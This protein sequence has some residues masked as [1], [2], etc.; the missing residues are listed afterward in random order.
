MRRP[1]V[2]MGWA[3]WAKSRRPPNAGA[4]EFQAKKSKIIS[5]LQ[6]VKL[7]TDLQ[8][9]DCEM[10]KNA[11]GGRAPTGPA[12]GAINHVLPMEVIFCR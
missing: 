7:L 1:G 2:A 5:P 3:G 11:F 8:I 9:L 10:H 4:P 6:W 12:G